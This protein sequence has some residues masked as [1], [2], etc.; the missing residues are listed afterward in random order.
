MIEVLG[1]NYMQYLLEYI[2]FNSV[3]SCLSY[4]A[5][6]ACNHTP[7]RP[8]AKVILVCVANLQVLI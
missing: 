8:L 7:H 5:G 6:L 4:T 2:S 3:F 1:L